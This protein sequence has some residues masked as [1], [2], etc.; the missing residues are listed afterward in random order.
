MELYLTVDNYFEYFLTILGWVI[1][2][3]LWDLFTQSGLIILPFIAHA[4]RLFLK[5]REQ[6]DDE[7]N[8]GR[9]LA[10]WLEN[11]FYTSIIILFL[12]CFPLFKV[13]Y[14]TLQLDGN[15]TTE[16]GRPVLKPENTGLAGLS[17]ELNGQSAYVPLWWAFTYTLS[18]GFTHGAIAAIPCKP[19]L[20]QIRFDIQNTQIKSPIL[21]QEVEEFVQQ[22]FVPARTKVKRQQ[23]ELD[24]VQSRDLDWIGSSLMLNTKGLYDSFRSQSPRIQFPY[25]ANRDVGLPNTGLGG[26]PNCKEWWSDSTVGLRA[27]LIDQVEPDLWTR[28]SKAWENNED[29]HDIVIRRLVSPENLQ[30]SNGRV[31]GSYASSTVDQVTGLPIVSALSQTA[32]IVGTT[33]GSVLTKPL[34]DTIR[35]SLPMIQS[36]ILLAIT[37]GMPIVVLFSSYDIRAV[38]TLSV[39]QFAVIF[40]SFWWELARWLDTWL[41]GTLYGSSTH[42][43]WNWAG[44]QNTQDDLIQN[45]VVWTLFLVFPVLWFGMLTWTGIKAGT[46][47]SNAIN[48]STN[49]VSETTQKG[50][51]FAT[52]AGKATKNKITRN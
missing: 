6:G 45:L 43:M 18:K 14:T 28:V 1:S 3:N 38:I 12:T 48:T 11:S 19:D 47:I 36:F 26:F 27:R 15:R 50:M 39:M 4:V 8:K 51:D 41:L 16:C 9:L 20:R 25:D 33:V 24:E 7:G 44:I 21:R 29:Y 37:I 35:A 49:K 52:S 30:V 2:N 10:A 13:S 40:L 17:S 32:G 31:Y 46:F 22:C 23:Y 42:S 5:V 34:F